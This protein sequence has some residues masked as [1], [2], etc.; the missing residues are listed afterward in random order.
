MPHE[1]T[2]ALKALFAKTPATDH[3]EF[4]DGIADFLATNSFECLGSKHDIYDAVDN[5]RIAAGTKE[6]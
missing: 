2:I 5:L 1:V 3:N 6:D 4:L